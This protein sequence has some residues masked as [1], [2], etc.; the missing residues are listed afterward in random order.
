MS[1]DDIGR[2]G[3]ADEFLN[4]QIADTFAA[5]GTSDLG[6][7]Q[8]VWAAFARKD[9]SLSISFGLGKYHNR[10]VMDAFAGVSRGTAQWTVRA[11]RRLDRAFDDLAVGPIHYEVVEPLRAIRFRLDANHTQPIAFDVLFTGVLPPFF[12]KRN[13]RR[14]ST[15]QMMDAVR[16]HQP[17]RLSGWVEI[18]GE[19]QSIGDDW[20]GF[21]DH[22]WGTRGKG[23]GM[24]L[25]D[26]PPDQGIGNMRLL[27]GPWLFERADGAHFELMNYWVAG[28]NWQYFSAHR[29][30]AGPGPDGV[31]QTEVRSMR[32]DLRFDPATRRLLG[33]TCTFELATGETLDVAVETLGASGFHLRTGEYGEWRGGRHGSWR[34]DYHEGGEHIPDVIAALPSLGQFRDAPVRLRLGDLVGYGIQESIYTGVF[35]DL[36]LTAESDYPTDL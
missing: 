12:E 34:G 20:F 10:N 18:D 7:T 16:Y 3:P 5:V 9:G 22:S 30:E 26:G 11:S 15:R 13:R 29:N 6:W 33:G 14:S 4:H 35:P 31:R 24:P 32:P 8:K 25:P 19:R 23:I 27:W 1:I 28:D 21:R 17:G 2:L 36:G